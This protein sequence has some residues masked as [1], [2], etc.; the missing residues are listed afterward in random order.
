M[1]SILLPVKEVRILQERPWLIFTTSKKE[2]WS[3][4]WPAIRK[5]FNRWHSSK[6]PILSRWAFKV[7]TPLRS[8]TSEQESLRRV[9]CSVTTPWTRYASTQMWMDHAYNLSQS[10]TTQPS[11]CGDMT[12]T[13]NRS[14]CSTWRHRSSLTVLIFA[15]LPSRICLR[16][17][18][19]TNMMRTCLFLTPLW[20]LVRVN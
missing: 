4:D 13:R 17:Q 14:L 7:R 12:S 8:G 15:R 11:Q 9:P 19:K 18:G 16:S 5:E 10:A 1:E 6:N 3:P 20:E 2:S